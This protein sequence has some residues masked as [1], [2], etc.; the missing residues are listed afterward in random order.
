VGIELTRQEGLLELAIQDNGVGFDVNKA[1]D[2][3]AN[4]GHLGLLGMKERVE[5]LGGTLQID[6]Q[7]GRGTRIR[8][9]LPEQ[10]GLPVQHA[11]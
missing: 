3:A 1:V 8:V 9:S 7:P 4:I 5:I 10:S 2:Q 6:S 11:A